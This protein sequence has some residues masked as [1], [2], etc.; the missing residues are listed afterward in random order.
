MPRRSS[1]ADSGFTIG[2]IGT[3][4]I[5]QEAVENLVLDFLEAQDVTNETDLQFIVPITEDGFSD[6]LEHVCG[7]AKDNEIPYA[8]VIDT[9]ASGA[10]KSIK[11]HI[12]E[13]F[14]S[15]KVEDVNAQVVSLLKKAARPHLFVLFEE[16]DEEANDE[17]VALAEDA[18][19]AEVKVF[20]LTDALTALQ[21]D[22]DGGED[23]DEEEAEPEP[24]PEKPSRRRRSA[25]EPEPEPEE[26]EISE[27]NPNEFVARLVK[28]LSD[29]IEEYFPDTAEEIKSASAPQPEP[30][31]PS[32]RRS[33]AKA[34]P[35]PEPEAEAPRRTS[36]ARKAAAP[37]EEPTED[38]PRR[39]RGRP[40]KDGTPAQPRVADPSTG[41]RLRRG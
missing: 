27:F 23:G 12:D 11:K 21:P 13:A 28:A 18:F 5:D 3:G 25:P 4:Q 15:H 22:E 9:A 29:L 1:A 14:K 2:F 26:S 31:K 20:D 24:E 16:D 8:A 7:L 38:A 33:S 19:E 32:R 40:R 35:E 6:T 34:E 30:E 10:P 36:R 17:L 39:S 41:R 37:V